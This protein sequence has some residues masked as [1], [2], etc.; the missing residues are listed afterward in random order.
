MSNVQSEIH[1]QATPNRYALRHAGT[2]ISDSVSNE[3]REEAGSF[4]GLPLRSQ[5]SFIPPLYKSKSMMTER[6]AQNYGRI[7]K[8]FPDRNRPL[9][10]QLRS[11]MEPLQRNRDG[12]LHELK[13]GLAIE[14]FSSRYNFEEQSIEEDS[15][16][17]QSSMN[18]SSQMQGDNPNMIKRKISV[19]SNTNSSVSPMILK[20]SKSLDAGNGQ[21][22]EP[23]NNNLLSFPGL[24][25]QFSTNLTPA[26]MER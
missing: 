25:K 11:E 8:D 22:I 5:I 2:I 24:D 16:S 26:V 9:Y 20:N 21:P 18:N 6:R 17:H 15:M 19:N 3:S 1:Q 7:A 4:K 14:K 10:S 13:Q 12:I 23:T